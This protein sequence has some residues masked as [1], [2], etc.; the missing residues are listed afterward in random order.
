M[1]PRETLPWDNLA[2]RYNGRELSEGLGH[3][4]QAMLL[5]QRTDMLFK[6]LPRISP[7]RSVRRGYGPGREG[8]RADLI[9]R[10]RI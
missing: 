3:A 6:T 5:D 1:Y 2:L 10:I 8:T 4:M 7:S 9:R